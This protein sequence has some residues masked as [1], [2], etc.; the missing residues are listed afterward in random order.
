MN[1]VL[2]ILH[3]GSLAPVARRPVPRHRERRGGK[4]VDVE[5]A[6]D[7]DGDPTIVWVPAGSDDTPDRR[8]TAGFDEVV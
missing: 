6:A 1:R 2:T 3:P 4:I 7:G 5:P 8:R